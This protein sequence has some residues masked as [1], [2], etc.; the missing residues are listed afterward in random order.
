MIA[1]RR[2]GTFLVVDMKLAQAHGIVLAGL[3]A[4]LSY[5]SRITKKD[6]HGYFRKDSKY[7]YEILGLS[8]MSF[9]RYRNKLQELGLIDFIPGKNQNEKCRYKVML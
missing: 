4:E 1:K 6:D 9:M 8:K 7:I 2:N 5:L 3:L